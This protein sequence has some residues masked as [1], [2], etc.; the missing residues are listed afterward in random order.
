MLID[1]EKSRRALETSRRPCLKDFAIVNPAVGCLT[2]CLFCGLSPAKNPGPAA[3]IKENLPQL[4]AQELK[5]WG[6]SRPLP[7]AILFDTATDS[8]QKLE[9]LEEVVFESMKLVLEEGFYV[10]FLSRNCPSPRFGKLFSRFS[11]KVFAQISFFTMDEKLAAIYEPNAPPPLERIEGVRRL[12][13][14]GVE[15]RARLDPIIPLI[16]D[17]A[18]HFE[19]L[20]RFIRSAGVKKII[21]NYLVLRPHLMPVFEKHLPPSHL[22]L[23]RGSFKGQGWIKAGLNRMT[24]L[25]PPNI[26]IKGYERLQRVAEKFSMP[27]DICQCDN[28]EGGLGCFRD[29][30]TRQKRLAAGQLELF[31]ST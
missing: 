12:V 16:S 15:V 3:R 4:L 21:A 19:E 20:L 25:L 10:Y 13:D 7:R 17:T 5:Q 26:R 1:A 24:K 23:I 27:V 6:E 8:F 22:E 29:H 18:G 9:G 28:P 14:W 31:E 2:G 30:L 11:E